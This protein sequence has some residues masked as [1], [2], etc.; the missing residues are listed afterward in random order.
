MRSKRLSQTLAL[1]LWVGATMPFAFAELTRGTIARIGDWTVYELRDGSLQVCYAETHLMAT[2][3]P[4]RGLI[5]T[6]LQATPHSMGAGA[7]MVRL[8]LG[9]DF[10]EPDDAGRTIRF[11]L[12]FREGQDFG[13]PHDLETSESRFSDGGQLVDEMRAAEKAGWPGIFR[14]HVGGEWTG[15]VAGLY[16]LG[17][18]SEAY[19]VART[20]C[21]AASEALTPEP[22]SVSQL[23]VHEPPPTADESMEEGDRDALFREW[24]AQEPY[25]EFDIVGRSFF[26]GQSEEKLTLRAVLG[27]KKGYPANVGRY[28]RERALN[29]ILSHGTRHLELYRNGDFF[30]SEEDPWTSGQY[31]FDGACAGGEGRLHLL[32]S[33]WS[34]GA[35][36][37]MADWAAH[38]VPENAIVWRSLKG[39]IDVNL[40]QVAC[41]TGQRYWVWGSTFRP[42]ACGGWAWPT[43]YSA[44]LK[45]WR[46]AF[47]RT[48]FGTAVTA[49][50]PVV[51]DATLSALLE[52]GS[53]LARFAEWD[54]YVDIHVKRFESATFEVVSVFYGAKLDFYASFQYVLARRLDGPSWLRVHYGK[55]LRQSKSIVDIYGFGEAHQLRREPTTE[56]HWEGKRGE[57]TVDLRSIF[58][59]AEAALDVD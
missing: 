30:H 23:R 8:R 51:D 19:D 10:F 2:P 24:L 7:D 52:Q 14:R 43:P 37:G 58:D 39:P 26:Q 32:V 15:E 57:Q 36:E 12:A 44:A 34:G 25:V 46:T 50:L 22:I 31:H 21:R 20:H 27:D 47:W 45:T 49:S 55:I 5:G 40:S 28:V 54:P 6:A 13:Y 56:E 16:S 4:D 41:G 29:S 38:H 59:E 1:A 42:C 53:R 18:F 17:G 9:D 33:I 48:A 11:R 3:A 35:S